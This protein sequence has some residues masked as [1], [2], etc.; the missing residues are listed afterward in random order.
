MIARL[1]KGLVI[2]AALLAALFLTIHAIN[3]YVSKVTK[4]KVYTS[5]DAIPYNEVGL[6]LGTSKYMANGHI[7]YYYQYRIDATLALFKAGKIK[8]VLV[9]GD[10]GT[11]S[12]NE[13]VT[14]K[15]DLISGGI[16]AE[17]IYL[18][19]A[20]FRTLDSIV[21]IWKIFDQTKFTVISQRFHNERAIYIA[22]H[23]N[24]EAIGFN[25]SNVTEKYGFKTMQREKLARMKML[26][27]LI[28]NIQP[29]FLG[30]KVQIA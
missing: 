17:F 28:F 8:Y 29:K 24:L 15:R 1:K 30:E 11:K 27:D 13:P 21:R 25:A 9:S 23:Y 7:N 4:D 19:Y 26:M 20:G 14:M 18:D 6:L 2:S 10:N 16:P 22:E 12:Y 5:I 3:V